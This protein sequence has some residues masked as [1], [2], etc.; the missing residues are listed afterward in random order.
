[1][2]TNSENGKPATCPC[3]G[4]REPS[5]L[6][7]EHGLCDTCM[8]DHLRAA[9]AGDLVFRQ[10]YNDALNAYPSDDTPIDEIDHFEEYE[11][12]DYY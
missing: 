8:N 6:T 10:I 11:Y 9:N 12:Q 7:T 2:K 5:W 1:M 3:C 4:L